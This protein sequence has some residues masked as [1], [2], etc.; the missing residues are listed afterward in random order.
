MEKREADVD[1]EGNEDESFGDG[2]NKQ[3]SRNECEDRDGIDDGNSDGEATSISGKSRLCTRSLF[4]IADSLTINDLIV[5]NRV[6]EGEVQCTLPLRNCGHATMWR[7]KLRNYAQWLSCVWYFPRLLVAICRS[8][9]PCFSSPS[10]VLYL[11]PY[12]A[13]CL[14]SM[15]LRTCCS[16]VPEMA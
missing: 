6:S 7:Q 5:D 16:G 10:S 13:G 2:D 8:R 15:S 3:G 14:D 9:E 1:G 4:E 12:D 11:K